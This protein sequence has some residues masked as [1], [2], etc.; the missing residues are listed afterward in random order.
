[1]KRSLLLSL[2]LL[3]FL[4]GC[5]MGHINEVDQIIINEMN[6]FSEVKA[7][8]SVKITNSDDM[9]VLIKGVEKAVKEPGVADVMDPEFELLIGERKFFLWLIGEGTVMDQEDTHTIYT[10]RNGV[11][12][13]IEKIIDEEYD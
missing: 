9:R 6:S 10:L 13:K 8:S 2:I 3:I 7:D 12:E 11:R 1:M 4:S 5:S